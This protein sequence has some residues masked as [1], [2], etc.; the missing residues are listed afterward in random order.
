M[1]T[2]Y[3]PAVLACSNDQGS[4]T[5]KARAQPTRSCAVGGSS[6]PQAGSGSSSRGSASDGAAHGGC[7]SEELEGDIPSAPLLTSFGLPPARQD[8]TVIPKTADATKPRLGLQA[9]RV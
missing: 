9:G 5:A 7:I 4:V 2:P 8:R 3:P 1:L 6:A